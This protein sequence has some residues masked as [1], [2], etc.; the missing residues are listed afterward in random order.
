MR[1]LP[2]AARTP[3]FSG[4][5][6]L[7]IF[8][9]SCKKISSRAAGLFVALLGRRGDERG[10]PGARERSCRA[11]TKVVGPTLESDD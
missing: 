9:S 10:E 2:A 7:P 6:A 3:R 4:F 11:G 5:L 1:Q 8:P